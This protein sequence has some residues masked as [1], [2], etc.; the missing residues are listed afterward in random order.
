MR[1]P[2][3]MEY[4]H[5]NNG[6]GGDQVFN[7]STGSS[8][9]LPLLTAHLV[10]YSF[11]FPL[12]KRKKKEDQVYSYSLTETNEHV[13]LFLAKNTEVEKLWYLFIKVLN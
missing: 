11:I 5:H 12:L 7:T 6:V 10:K 4:W 13:G 8:P 3:H 9:P 2:G 1:S